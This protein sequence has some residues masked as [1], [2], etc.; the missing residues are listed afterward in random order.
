MDNITHSLT[1]LFLSR[2]LLNRFTPAA[3]PLLIIAAN[4][5]DLDIVSAL[6]GALNYL[7]WHRHLTHSFFLAPFLALALALVFHFFR[8]DVSV[9][10]AFA[11]ALC[12]VLSH[13]LLDLTNIYGVRVLLPFRATW[14]HWD[15][16]PV[17]DVWIW[18]ALALGLAAPFLSRLVASEI[19][20]TRDSTG[21]RG[22]AIAA[23]LFLG[24]YNGGRAILH[25]RVLQTLNARE[26]D[27]AP[28]LRVAAFP[29]SMNPLHWRGVAETG[30]TYNLFDFKPP[31]AFNPGL[32]EIVPK[33]EASPAIEAASQTPAFQVYADF[34]QYPFYRVIPLA[35]PEGGQRVELS[36]L[37]FNF[38]STAVLNRQGQV[39][40]SAFTFGPPAPR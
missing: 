36:D 35:E 17:I 3:T 15:L 39:A 33:T 23:L 13:V 8:R 16:T 12:G 30:S 18:A 5:P 6:G 20:G 9:L 4:L 24:L 7:H 40:S 26:Y 21:G 14:Y 38:T 10:P 2:A 1:G 32:A 22:F 34:A 37:R 27:G 29:E 25:N 11:V 19:G 31:F 28:P